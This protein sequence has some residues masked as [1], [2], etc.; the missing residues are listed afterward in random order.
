MVVNG[1]VSELTWSQGLLDCKLPNQ[2]PLE[3]IPKNIIQTIAL[4]QPPHIMDMH[5]MVREISKEVVGVEV[6][7]ILPN[8]ND[9]LRVGNIP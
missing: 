4:Y 7:Q 2:V 1:L 6:E 8:D 9:A 5:A 3:D